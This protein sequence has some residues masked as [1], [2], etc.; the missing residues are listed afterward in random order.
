[1]EIQHD[2]TC[3]C[4][5]P[6]IKAIIRCGE[7][8]HAIMCE[9]NKLQC[10]EIFCD[11]VDSDDGCTWGFPRERAECD[12][13]KNNQETCSIKEMLINQFQGGHIMKTKL[14]ISG[15]AA[16][17]LAVVGI[18]KLRRRRKRRCAG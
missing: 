18:I 9:N 6:P 3:T 10:D 8:E 17:V 11:Y 4:Y 5:Y 14:I 12:F 1:M 7:C 2:I 16:C 15:V 13:C